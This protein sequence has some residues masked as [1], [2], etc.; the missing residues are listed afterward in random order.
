[1]SFEVHFAASASIAQIGALLQQ[2]R[3]QL[4]GGPDTSDAYLLRGA[5]AQAAVA[6]RALDASP[7][8]VSWA[9]AR[10]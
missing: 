9:Q 8:V 3:L 4:A 10:R 1:M 5:A 7:L 6:R 2:P